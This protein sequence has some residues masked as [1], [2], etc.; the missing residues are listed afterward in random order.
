MIF[1]FVISSN[2]PSILQP[3]MRNCPISFDPLFINFSGVRLVK[4]L[5]VPLM[6]ILNEQLCSPKG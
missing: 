6:K 5:S 1:L 3:F 2:V 4:L